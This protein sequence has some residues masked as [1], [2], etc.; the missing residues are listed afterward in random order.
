MTT[1]TTH[2]IT[3]THWPQL[4]VNARQ[5]SWA[6]AA[7]WIVRFVRRAPGTGRKMLDQSA[8]WLNGDHWDDTRWHPIG[9]RLIPPD[10]LRQVEAWLRSQA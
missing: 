7:H 8:A 5:S 4:V 6:G 3:L 2:T 10:A 9:Q 1:T